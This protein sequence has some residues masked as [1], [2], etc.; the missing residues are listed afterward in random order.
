MGE[1]AEIIIDSNVEHSKSLEKF[2]NILEAARVKEDL[3]AKN[4]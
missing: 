4:S 1:A 2:V 3:A